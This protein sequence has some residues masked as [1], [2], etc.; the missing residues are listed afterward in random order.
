MASERRH[1]IQRRE[2]LSVLAA[3]R[4]GHGWATKGELIYQLGVRNSELDRCVD[5]LEHADGLQVV[6]LGRITLLVAPTNDVDQ[7][8]AQLFDDHERHWR[9]RIGDRN[10]RLGGYR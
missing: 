10:T 3:V 9:A 1:E 2:C 7:A 6:D 8:I 5:V 4:D